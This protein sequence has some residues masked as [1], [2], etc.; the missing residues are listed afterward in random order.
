[1]N[2]SSSPVNYGLVTSWILVYTGELTVLLLLFLNAQ[3]MN[4]CQTHCRPVQ[5]QGLP[6]IILLKVG[7][8]KKKKKTLFAFSQP[9]GQVRGR[10]VSCKK[11]EE[12]EVCCILHR[13]VIASSHP[14]DGERVFRLLEWL[15]H[16]WGSQ[17]DLLLAVAYS[18]LARILSLWRCVTFIAAGTETE[19]GTAIN[20]NVCCARYNKATSKLRFIALFAGKSQ[21]T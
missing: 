11:W 4:C 1:M 20:S 10:L 6:V 13:S 18:R 17:C 3:A 7:V 16:H 2:Y 14:A 9:W 5:S 8:R 12:T 15:L 19:S 21:Q